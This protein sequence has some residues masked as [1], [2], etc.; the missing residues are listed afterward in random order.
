M[1]GKRVFLTGHTGFKG[2]WLSLWLHKLGAEATGYSLPAESPG[3]FAAAG[4]QEL[5][6]HTEGDL[7]DFEKLKQAVRE[8]EPELILHLAAQ[9]LVLASYKEPKETFDINVGGTVNL[10]EAARECPSVKAILIIT[11]DKVYE[12]REWEWGYRETDRLGGSDPYSASKSMTELLADSYRRSFFEERGVALATARAGNVIGGGDF[13]P[14]R[15]LP[16][17]MRALAAGRPVEL[18]NPESVRPWLHVLEPLRGYLLLAEK[19]LEEGSAFAEAWNFGPKEA[20]GVCCREVVER[21]IA[22][23]GDGDW[24]D[25]SSPDTKKEMTLLKLNWE[26]AAKRLNW[27]PRY[28][29]EEAV[30]ETVRW[31]R[32]YLEGEPMQPFC[33]AQI[34]RYMQEVPA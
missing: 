28:S 16:D 14:F 24:A 13:A 2:S 6:C 12:N 26:R 3:N 11:T 30:E 15:L 25:A 1:R 18:R 23:W 5:I 8:A 9:P 32:A 7:R 21:A 10:L 33:L 29:W 20:Q 31:F 19:L 4:V 34:S 22:C 27:Q 17:C